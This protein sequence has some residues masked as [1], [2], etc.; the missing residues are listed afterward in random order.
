MGDVHFEAF[1][2]NRLDLFA[3]QVTLLALLHHVLIQAQDPQALARSIGELANGTVDL[4]P[5]HGDTP[6]EKKAVAKEI[7]RAKV[8]ELITSAL[9]P[10]P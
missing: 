8:D 1:E 10:R 3:I 9:Q 7:M 5:F 2:L 4:F 6:E